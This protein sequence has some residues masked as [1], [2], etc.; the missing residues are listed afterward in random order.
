MKLTS[1]GSTAGSSVKR[2]SSNT[3][4]NEFRKT[5][6][7]PGNGQISYSKRFNYMS[8]TQ[9]EVMMNMLEDKILSIMKKST[10]IYGVLQKYGVDV[11]TIGR[12]LFKDKFF[13]AGNFIVIYSRIKSR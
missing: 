6:S 2:Q 9:A 13:K 10:S 1:Q 7:T 4:Q 12:L 3:L 5:Q 8:P 11:G